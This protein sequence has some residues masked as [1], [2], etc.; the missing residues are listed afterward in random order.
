MHNESKKI[1]FAVLDIIRRKCDLTPQ[2]TQLEIAT[3]EEM[4]KNLKEEATLMVSSNTF[5]RMFPFLYPKLKLIKLYE[6]DAKAIGLNFKEEL[7]S[8]LGVL[9]E[10]HFLE[11]YILQNRT[12][13][14]KNPYYE[15]VLPDDFDKLHDQFVNAEGDKEPPVE[16]FKENVVK[17][18]FMHEI[19]AEVDKA[20]APIREWRHQEKLE[21]QRAKNERIL[22]STK[23]KYVHALDTIIERLESYNDG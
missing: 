1:L 8:V 10:K 6:N 9:K 23:D 2:P 22:R 12:P 14:A 16:L 19:M 21:R 3:R 20:N 17:P 13:N 11:D 15:I 18:V 5:L 4:Q 7:A